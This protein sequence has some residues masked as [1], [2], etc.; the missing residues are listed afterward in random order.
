MKSSWRGFLGEASRKSSVRRGLRPVVQGR[1]GTCMAVAGTSDS[2]ESESEGVTT[3]ADTDDSESD[4]GMSAAESDENENSSVRMFAENGDND[5]SRSEVVATVAESDEDEI[6]VNLF[7]SLVMGR[8]LEW[9]CRM[10]RSGGIIA[11]E[12]LW[13]ALRGPKLS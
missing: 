5:G 9:C 10:F 2:D 12:N 6:D 8:A 13:Q 11:T 7:V 3:L 4:T 1:V